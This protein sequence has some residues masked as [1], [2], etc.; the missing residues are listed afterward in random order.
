MNIF[1]LSIFASTFLWS[2]T[3]ETKFLILFLL[4][5]TT[6]YLL[7]TLLPTNPKKSLYSTIFES[8]TNPTIHTIIPINLTKIDK[9]LLT[10]N[11]SFPENRITYTHIGLK[12]LSEAMRSFPLTNAYI[13]YNNLYSLN[14]I[15]NIG[16]IV[17]VNGKDLSAKVI[18]KIENYG[19]CKIPRTLR[20]GV[21][22]IKKGKDRRLNSMNRALRFLPSYVFNFFMEIFAFFVFNLFL[23]IEKFSFFRKNF[24]LAGL[25]N[26]SSFGL[27]EA[28]ACH[29]SLGRT[30]YVFLMGSCEK[31]AVVVNGRIEVQNVMN[32]GVIGDL[33]LGNGDDFLNSVKKIEEVFENF[34]DYIN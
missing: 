30:A 28:V 32:V 25:T 3:Y 15:T 23:K 16:V 10:H 27:K 6:K 19:I 21:K 9:Y 24:A 12:A 2:I 22:M 13:S 14:S 20:K 26:V 33:R 5:L 11:K 31:K 1:F 29:I 8:P 17:S 4:I 34:E 18:R 7:H